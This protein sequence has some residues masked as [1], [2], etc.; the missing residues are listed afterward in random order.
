[1]KS[2]DPAKDQTLIDIKI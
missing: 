1:M 2:S